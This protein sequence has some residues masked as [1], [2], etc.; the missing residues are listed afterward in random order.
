MLS[1]TSGEQ[2]NSSAQQGAEEL[3]AQAKELFKQQ[4][5]ILEKP[6]NMRQGRQDRNE[7]MESRLGPRT[8]FKCGSLTHFIRDCSHQVR[9]DQGNGRCTGRKRK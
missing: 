7:S 4:T 5:E 1:S 3:P 2:E 9:P 8:C 6:K